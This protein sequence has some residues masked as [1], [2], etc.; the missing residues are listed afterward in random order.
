MDDVIVATV[1]PCAASW[2]YVLFVTVATHA[3]SAQQCWVMLYL[4]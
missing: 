2:E 3:N 4:Y 1:D